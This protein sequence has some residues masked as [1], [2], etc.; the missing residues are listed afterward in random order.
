MSQQV[1]PRIRD[2]LTVA[3]V[4]ISELQRA[5][6]GGGGYVGG[7]GV[8]VCGRGRWGVWEGRVCKRMLH[9]KLH[10]QRVQLVSGAA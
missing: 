10:L 6:R 7:G 3:Q 5:E 8:R 4:D 9:V 2:V 1:H